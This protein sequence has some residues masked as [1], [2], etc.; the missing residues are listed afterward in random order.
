MRIPCPH[1][2]TR[3]IA[4]FRYGGAA[5]VERPADPA[6]AGDAAWADYLFYRDNPKGPYRE[7][8][9]HAYGCRRWFELER[10]TVT[11]EILRV[12]GGVPDVTPGTTEGDPP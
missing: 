12:P 11:H 8:W 2:G 1:C 7:R 10:D 3:D 5:G 9:V 6:A 4:E